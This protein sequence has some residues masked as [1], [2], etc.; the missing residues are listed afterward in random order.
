MYTTHIL[1]HMGVKTEQQHTNIS[2]IYYF[3]TQYWMAF[4]VKS[5]IFNGNKISQLNFIFHLFE[6][7]NINTTNIHD[8]TEQRAWPGC[9]SYNKQILTLLTATT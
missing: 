3:G 9:A 7:E 5:C 2:A 1:G 8:S 4:S 6:T